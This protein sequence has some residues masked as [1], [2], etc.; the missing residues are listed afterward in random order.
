MVIFFLI[1]GVLP[2][3]YRKGFGPIFSL[4]VSL[5]GIIQPIII[6]AISEKK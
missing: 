1:L 5:L 3:L 6:F 2:E 4:Y